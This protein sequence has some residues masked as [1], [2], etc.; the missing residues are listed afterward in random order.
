MTPEAQ[1]NAIAKS[2]GIDVPCGCIESR[3]IIQY[4]GIKIGD[5]EKKM[6]PLPDWL[7][8]RDAIIEAVK[9]C[10]EEQQGKMWAILYGLATG[11]SWNW[12]TVVDRSH[13]M[14]C[15]TASA[16]MLCEAYLKTVNLWVED[17]KGGMILCQ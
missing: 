6:F 4:I 7:N 3:P 8:D 14:E 9:T 16:A 12:T 1:V 10:N 15:L 17:G 2:L 5:P 13:L 11:H